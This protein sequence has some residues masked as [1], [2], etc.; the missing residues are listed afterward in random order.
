[1]SSLARIVVV[2]GTGYTGGNIVAEAAS[3]GHDV[4][5]ISRSAPREAAPGVRYEL[6]D[7]EKLAPQVVSGADVV[8]AALSPR[9]PM[10]GRLVDVYAELA[11]LSAETGA[12]YL[13]VGGFGKPAEG[14]RAGTGNNTP[15]QRHSAAL[16]EPYTLGEGSKAAT[17][18]SSTVAKGD[19]EGDASIAADADASNTEETEKMQAYAVPSPRTYF[20]HFI[21]HPAHFARFLET[22]ALARWG[23]VVDM[24]A[25][26]PADD[27][28]P[29]PDAP[30]YIDTAGDAHGEEEVD[31]VERALRELGLDAGSETGYEDQEVLDQ[32]SIW[33][34]LLEL[35]LTSAA[36]HA[37]NQRQ[38]A[39]KLLQQ[40]TSL[41]YDP[42]H[43]VM[44][45]AVEQFHDGL[46]LLYER[47]GMYEDVVRLHMDAA[48]S[49][50][51]A[52]ESAKVISALQRYGSLRPDL[53][54]LVLR[55]LV[56]SPSLLARHT[57]DLLSI[58]NTIRDKQLM[59]TLEIVQTLS[60]TPH[61]PVG[62][63]REFIVSSIT[64]TLTS[65]DADMAAIGDYKTSTEETL[66][67][68]GELTDSA[69][70]R[71]FQMAR[72]TACGGQ[73]D[74]PSVHFMC[75]HSYHQRCLGE[76][77]AECPTC[78]THQGRVRDLRR[79]QAERALEVAE[80]AREKGSVRG[81]INAAAA[82]GG[83]GLGRDA[84]GELASLFAQPIMGSAYAAQML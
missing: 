78:A 16:V 20:A 45:C 59:S 43:A 1:M 70:A 80:A 2:G 21:Q 28:L 55:F 30:A 42:S 27:P 7:V 31:E 77:E 68:I 57:T 25:T 62:I 26:A 9:G 44:L 3:R 48:L 23:Q 47:M 72:C 71:V 4:V 50:D 81:V 67:E 79:R 54:D 58:L 18:P 19:A 51:S 49:D 14:S 39:L 8:V 37:P 22:V 61:T 40:H 66:A 17:R 52:G 83:V 29:Q 84:F 24:D 74:L 76:E 56:S 36:E 41:P 82:G 65:T 32:K 63:V 38:R 13:Q 10:A 75:K 60:S 73:L 35:Y 53:Y 6:G 15:A 11:R 64:S 12:R 34:T 46:I 33:N 69:G 5:S